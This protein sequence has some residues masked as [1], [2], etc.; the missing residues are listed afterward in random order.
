MSLDVLYVWTNSEMQDYAL[1]A[2]NYVVLLVYDGG[3]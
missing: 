1:T 2:Q 3:L